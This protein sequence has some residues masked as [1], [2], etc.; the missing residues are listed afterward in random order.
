MG[1][2]VSFHP[3][4]VAFIHDRVVRYVVGD[5]EIDDLFASGTRIARNRYLANAW[6]LGVHRVHSE[7]FN[8]L[9]P[10][11]RSLL[12]R[13]LGRP[14][15]RATVPP[16]PFEFETDLFIWGRPFFITVP[17]VSEVTDLYLGARDDDAVTLL[18]REMS[19]RIEPGLSSRVIPDLEGGVPTDKEFRDSFTWKL[20]LFRSAFEAVRDGSFVIAPD[21]QKH[22]PVALFE[23]DFPLAALSFAA[24]FRPG[25]MARGYV[26]PT[27][28][29]EAAGLECPFFSDASRLFQPLVE[30]QPRIGFRLSSTIEDNYSIGGFVAPQD[31]GRLA[32]FLEQHHDAILAVGTSEGWE[33]D[34]RL[35]LQKIR[36]AVADAE[37]RGFG[38]LEA[39]EIYSGPLGV[40]N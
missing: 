8:A 6:G 21:G 10:P 36:E 24:H 31:V 33:H 11:K 17:E 13:F 38:F 37:A 2:D 4:D 39:S 18:A 14:A 25:W 1:Y 30:K 34:C 19:E 7:R 32:H 28:L 29:F 9:E 22:E 23:T 35:A 26:W 20:E 5:C 40:M 16:E 15:P 3:V 27:R 12:S